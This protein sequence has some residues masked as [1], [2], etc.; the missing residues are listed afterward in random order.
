MTPRV[1]VKA[2]SADATAPDVADL[3]RATGL[4]QFPVYRDNLDDIVGI[5]HV[6]G[7]LAVPVDAADHRRGGSTC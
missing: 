6:K 3:T 7:A 1:D 4:S 5:V 2:L